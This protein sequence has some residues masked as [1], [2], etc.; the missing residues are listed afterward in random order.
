MEGGAESPVS[1]EDG[2]KDPAKGKVLAPRKSVREVRDC[3]RGGDLYTAVN[4]AGAED[5]FYF[6]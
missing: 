4:P 5:L 6:G 1:T 2:G 3:T